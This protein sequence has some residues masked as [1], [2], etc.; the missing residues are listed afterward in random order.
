MSRKSDK[1]KPN[2]PAI[3]KNTVFFDRH[4]QPT[5]QLPDPEQP[6]MAK[7]MAYFVIGTIVLY[8]ILINLL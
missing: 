1:H 4:Q 8:L 7:Y 6:N 5:K 2:Q 3:I